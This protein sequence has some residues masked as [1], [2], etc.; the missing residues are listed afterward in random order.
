M[1]S[2]SLFCLN[3]VM[4]ISHMGSSDLTGSRLGQV[5]AE[6]RTGS[7]VAPMGGLKVAMCDVMMVIL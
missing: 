5:L 6:E 1:K 7:P 3:A 4:V 2:L